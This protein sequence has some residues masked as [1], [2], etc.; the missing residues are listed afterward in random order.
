MVFI[1]QKFD[2]ACSFQHLM[3]LKFTFTAF[4]FQCHYY[5]RALGS[6]YF[7][8]MCNDLNDIF[9]FVTFTAE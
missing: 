7:L 3:M 5:V 1:L 2:I 4:H 9:L 8:L 6:S